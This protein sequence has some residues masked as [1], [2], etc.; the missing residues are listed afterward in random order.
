MKSSIT[1]IERRFDLS[2]THVG[3][4]DGS[5]E[6][7]TVCSCRLSARP[8]S[9]TLTSPRMLSLRCRQPVVFSRRQLLWG[10]AASAQTHSRG[11]SPHGRRGPCHGADALL[12]G[13]VRVCSSRRLHGIP[14]T[15]GLTPLP[16]TGTGTTRLFRFSRTAA[17]TR[18]PVEP[19]RSRRRI[20]RT[21]KVRMSLCSQWVFLG[22]R[23][24]LVCCTW[25]T[26]DLCGSFEPCVCR[27]RNHNKYG[28]ERDVSAHQILSRRLRAVCTPASVSEGP[29]RPP[30]ARLFATTLFFCC[31]AIIIFPSHKN[32]HCAR[33]EC[34][35]RIPFSREGELY[36]E[37]SAT[38]TSPTIPRS[39]V[40]IHA[41]AST[42]SA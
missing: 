25:L 34:D 15:S 14:L 17:G 9:A 36:L 42:P 4:V 12:H 26:L 16:C 22:R 5:F 18:R 6:M 37:G 1:Q 13:P 32:T 11:L 29:V 35:A 3:L 8:T 41:S 33:T 24:G 30:R 7:G 40:S 2:S 20:R 31:S 28:K 19:H 21:T 38:W 23:G 10:Q 27:Q 39:R